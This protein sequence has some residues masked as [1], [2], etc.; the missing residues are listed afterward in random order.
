MATSRRV[1]NYSTSAKAVIRASDQIFDAAMS[2]KPDFTKISQEAIK[3]RS[4]ERRA[5]TKAEGEVASAGLKAFTDVNLTKMREDTEK[6]IA[7][8]KRPA[9]RMAGA[10]AGLGAIAGGYVMME[11]NKKDKAERAQLKAERDAL[12]AKQ[13]ARWAKSDERYEQLIQQF[14][15]GGGGSSDPKPSTPVPSGAGSTTTPPA[16]TPVK[17]TATKPTKPTNGKYSRSGAFNQILSLAQSHGGFKFPEVVAAQAMHETGWMNPDMDSVYNSSG[18]TNPFG[19]T[20][21]RGYGTIPR[22]GFKDGWTLYPD[23]ETAVSDHHTLWHDTKN[24][25][26]NYNAHSDRTTAIRTVASA[27]SPNSDKDNIRLGYT[28]NGYVKGVNSALAE[29]NY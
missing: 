12:D 28:E 3:G 16:T 14:S 11:G 8:I 18:G 20:G 13:E 22:K 25:S 27:Y 29:M 19:Q 9:K 4:L 10:V 21:D 15:S 26:E 7:D 23:L 24:H 17:P 5:V 1:G 6:E 2:G